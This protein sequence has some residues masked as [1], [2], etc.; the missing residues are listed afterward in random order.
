MLLY[1]VI[2]FGLLVVWQLRGI[3][4]AIRSLKLDSALQDLKKEL[5]DELQWHKDNTFAN[6]LMED[7]KSHK[8]DLVRELESHK[9][10]IVNELQWHKPSSFAQVLIKGLEEIPTDITR[11][12]VP[13]LREILQELQRDR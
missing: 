8:K 6:R 12:I 10:D 4:S 13:E 5:K 9:E 11:D 7:L 1:V 2:V 3:L